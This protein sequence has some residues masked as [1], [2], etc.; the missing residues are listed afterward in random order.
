MK[1]FASKLYQRGVFFTLS[2]V[3]VLSTIFSA[4]LPFVFSQEAGAVP[5]LGNHTIT[6]NTSAGENLPGWMFNRDNNTKTPYSFNVGSPSI[7][8]GSLFVEPIQNNFAGTCSTSTP[9]PMPG[10]DKFVGENFILS[11]ISDV[12]SISVDYKLGASTNAN[13]IYMNVYANFGSSPATKYYDCRY[14]VV[15]TTGSTGSYSTLTFNT[16]SVYNNVRTASS[17]LHVCPTVPSDMNL[18]SSGSTIRAYSINLGDTSLS[19]NGMSAYFDNSVISTVSGNIVYDFEPLLDT[20]API[21]ELTAP[22]NNALV[23]GTVDVTGTVSDDVALS[24]WVLGLYPGSTDLSSG[25]PHSS[26]ISVPGWGQVNT[27]SDLVTFSRTLNTTTLV[28]GEYQIRLAARDA[29]TNRDVSN[30]F[31]GGVSSVHVIR[32]IVDNTPPSAPVLSSPGNNAP[33]KGTNLINDWQ[34][35][36][37]ASHYIYESYNVDGSGNCN[38]SSIRFTGT[39][40]DSQT[41]SR[42]VSDLVFCWRVK[43]VDTIGHESAWSELWKTVVD[44]TA[45]FVAI[46]SPTGSLFNTDVEV[47]GTVTDLHPR[48]YWLHITKNGSPIVNTTVISGSFTDQLLYTLT[49]DGDYVVTLA[50][51]DAVGGGSSTGNRSA[52]VVKTFTIDKTAP[53]VP[54]LTMLSGPTF[55]T[56][57]NSGDITNLDD[58]KI[59]LSSS[60]DTTRYTLKYWSDAPSAIFTASSPLEVDDVSLFFALALGEYIENFGLEGQHHFQFAACDAAGNCSSLSPDFTMYYDETAPTVDVLSYTTTNNQIVP[61]ATATDD[62]LPLQYTWVANNSASGNPANVTV[63]SLTALNPTFTVL[64]DGS[65]SFSLTVTDAAGNSTVKEFTFSYAT[66]QAPLAPATTP[67]D[68]T[69]TTG[70]GFTN[71]DVLGDSTTINETPDTDVEGV[72]AATTLAVTDTDASDGSVLGLAWYWW[73]L[74][75]AAIGAFIWWLI[76][77]LR[78]RNQGDQ[79]A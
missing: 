48:H 63:S 60:A 20:V 12:N 6:G 5:S 52:D 33:V 10:C 70:P 44:N 54:T 23:Q 67:L 19:D 71:V 17:S 3:L 56:M 16:S 36:A 13:Q 25:L 69:P 22:T 61:D 31:V 73:V 51:R 78:R 18:T 74:I 29:A 65:Y 77:F 9:A 8:S 35:V 76:G 41:N 4:A 64:V 32:I 34:S 38:L 2:T 37:G 72:T 53:S 47:R 43:A 24:H 30:P 1:A 40:I 57:L 50:A 15:A 28:D 46:T 58:F 75:I 27:S 62:S 55:A 66:P 79:S 49:E 45:P 11:N 7:G 42:D 59:A 21:V 68:D 14:D 39:Y 26:I